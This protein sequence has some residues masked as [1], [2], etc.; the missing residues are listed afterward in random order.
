MKE[1][2]RKRYVI[3]WNDEKE[4]IAA[5][6]EVGADRNPTQ[7][8]LSYLA[9]SWKWTPNEL[10][11][12]SKREEVHVFD[13]D[14]ETKLDPR[15]IGTVAL[16]RNDGE[17]DKVFTDLV[18]I[19]KGETVKQALIERATPKL[20][21]VITFK[22]PDEILNRTHGG[23]GTPLLTKVTGCDNM[24]TT[25]IGFVLF[26]DLSLTKTLRSFGLQRFWTEEPTDG[27]VWPSYVTADFS[28]YI[29]ELCEEHSIDAP[30]PLE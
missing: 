5:V 8:V 9:D 21:D 25:I 19:Y 4:P 16:F 28:A 13:V 11:E 20:S 23:E 14:E 26:I 15:I 18:P 10:N 12:R 30:C 3:I 27:F 1:V 24:T 6:I 7:A 22:I 29:Q 2:E 17:L